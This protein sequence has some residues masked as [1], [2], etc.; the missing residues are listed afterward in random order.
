M[1]VEVKRI[2]KSKQEAI[3]SDNDIEQDIRNSGTIVR[4]VIANDTIEPNIIQVVDDVTL[5]GKVSQSDSNRT[6]SQKVVDISSSVINKAIHSPEIEAR[7]AER[8]AQCNSPYGELSNQGNCPLLSHG[9]CSKYNSVEVDG[10][11]VHGCS[12]VVALKVYSKPTNAKDKP[13][14]PLNRWII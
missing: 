11:E 1:E 13:L 10:V 6:W 9:V 12:C 3:R 5:T 14:C 8:L 7:A 2:V 4:E